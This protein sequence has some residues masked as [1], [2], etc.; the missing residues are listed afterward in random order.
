MHSDKANDRCIAQMSE[1]QKDKIRVAIAKTKNHM[2][3]HVNKQFQDQLIED[4]Q[5]ILNCEDSDTLN[6]DIFLV[7]KVDPD[8]LKEGFRMLYLNTHHE[9]L[10]HMIKAYRVLQILSFDKDWIG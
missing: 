2:Q 1:G 9:D 4:L 6:Q 3:F 5:R 7:K 8:L 10:T